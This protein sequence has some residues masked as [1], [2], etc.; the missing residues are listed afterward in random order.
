MTGDLSKTE[1]RSSDQNFSLRCVLLN[2]HEWGLR[3]GKVVCT[4]C[5]KLA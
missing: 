5:G 2:L 3:N 1:A 4:R